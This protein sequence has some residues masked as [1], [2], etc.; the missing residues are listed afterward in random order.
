M[1]VKNIL[2]K[3]F[4]NVNLLVY[5]VS[6]QHTLMDGHRKYKVHDMCY[7]SCSPV[8]TAHDRNR[9]TRALYSSESYC[10]LFQRFNF[11][12]HNLPFSSNFAENYFRSES[13]LLFDEPVH[14][15]CRSS[16][17]SGNVNLLEL[18]AYIGLLYTDCFTLWRSVKL[19]DRLLKVLV[20]IKNSPFFP[21]A[22]SMWHFVEH[23]IW[24]HRCCN[25]WAAS[26]TCR[27]W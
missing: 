19:K 20:Y 2:L 1:L 27:K 7:F 8:V 21:M 13:P 5:H 26:N 15:L 3:L 24:Q 6:R 25:Y 23:C 18:Q 10:L 12:H 17:N 14:L 9:L 11:V 4:I 22:T 16:R